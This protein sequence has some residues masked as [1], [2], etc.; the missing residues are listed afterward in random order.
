M[1]SIRVIDET[2]SGGRVD[3][4]PL[5]V[6]SEPITVAD[7]IALRVRTEVRRHNNEGK[8]TFFGLVQPIQVESMINGKVESKFRHIDADTQVEVALRGFKAQRFVV[9]LPEG[10]ADSLEQTVMLS[11]GDAVSFLRLVPLIG[12]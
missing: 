12:G 5:E 9:L 11:D 2:T 8:G 7:L 10:Q 4:T 6:D 1:P 3:A